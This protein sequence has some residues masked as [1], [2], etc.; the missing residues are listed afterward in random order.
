MSWPAKLEVVTNPLTGEATALSVNGQTRRIG[1]LL[2]RSNVGTRIFGGRMGTFDNTTAK[3]FQVTA[4]LAQHFDAVRVLF[5]NGSNAASYT[6]GQLKLSSQAAAADLNNSAGSWVQGYM[7]GGATTA[8]VPA[9][10]SAVSRRGWFASD[11]VT[12]NSSDRSDGGAFP[13]VTARCTITTAA[14]ISIFGNGTDDYTNWVTRPNGRFWCMRHQDGDQVTAP[15]GFTSTVNRNQSPIVGFQYLARGQVITVMGAGDSITEGRGTY[16]GEGFGVPACEALSRMDGIAVEWCNVGISGAGTDII[17]NQIIDVLAAGIHPD[18]LVVPYGSPNDNGG[19]WL[20][21]NTLSIRGFLG[22]ALP[23]CRVA[24]VQPVLWTVLP[25][26]PASKAYGASDALRVAHNNDTLGMRDRG[27]DVMDFAAALSG[28]TDGNGQVAMLAGSTTDNI[29][30][31]DAG[32]AVLAPIL[33]E[34]IKEY[35]AF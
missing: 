6:I 27:V 7:A 10:A 4:T 33:V 29:H 15:A 26:N 20:A 28:V 11:W 34:K 22:Q 31:N 5:A 32:N 35:M 3:T 13:I 1:K 19:T 30:P 17:R 16:K 24:Q 12:L 18:L 21:S 2:R 23:A 8:P 14:P 25:T 9:A